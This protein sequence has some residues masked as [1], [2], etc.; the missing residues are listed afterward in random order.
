MFNR[1]NEADF[2]RNSLSIQAEKTA[3]IV[4]KRHLN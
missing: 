1:W 2:V 4:I 3:Q